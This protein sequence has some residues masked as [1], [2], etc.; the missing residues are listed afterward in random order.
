[1]LKTYIL[2]FIHNKG[3]GYAV[4]NAM[5]VQQAVSIL[6][7]Q[8][9]HSDVEVSTVVENKWNGQ[10]MQLVLEG[11]VTTIGRDLYDIAVANGFKGNESEFLQTLVG[12]QGPQGIPGPQGIQG[13]QGPQGPQGPEGPAGKDGKDGTNGIDGTSLTYSDLTTEEKND[14]AS[15]VDLSGINTALMSLLPVI[16]D[17]RQDAAVNMTGVAPFESLTNGQMI[18]LHFKYANAASPTLQLTL[19]NGT[20]TSVYPLYQNYNV[21]VNAL[22]LQ[23]MPAGS[24][25][26]FIFDEANNRWVLLGKDFNTTYSNTSQADISNSV[27]GSRLIEPK[28]LRDNFYL[29]S[30]VNNLC[31]II[32]DTRSSAVANIT[33]VAPFSS[34]VDGQRI[35]LH[36]QFDSAANTSITLTLGN[37]GQTMSLPVYSQNKDGVVRVAAGHIRAGSFVE[38]VYDA[39]NAQWSALGWRDTN[40]TY[41]AITQAE[42]DAGTQT[43]TRVITPKL[44]CDNFGKVTTL[45]EVQTTGDVTQALDS[46]KFYRFGEIDSLTITL[47]AAAAGMA[48]Y[49]GK[50]TASANWSALGLPATVDEAAGNDTIASGKTYEFN[51]FDDVIVIKEV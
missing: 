34:L 47:T 42:I 29:K 5:S 17:T 38:L 50:F 1:M 33:G 21:S 31:P 10:E 7:V 35:V 44:L 18:V 39:T 8:T 40:T 51:I 20:T 16:E 27:Q 24:Y 9:K 15:H 36:S 14:L 49:A 30:E 25:G 11:D 19:S 43:G 23:A 13:I 26:V 22:T 45:V 41:S 12:P 28:L 6:K 3:N 37:G 46:G 32:E 48:I 2:Q 4:V